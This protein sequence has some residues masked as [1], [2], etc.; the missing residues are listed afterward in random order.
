MA[1][2][3]GLDGVGS[4]LSRLKDFLCTFLHSVETGCEAHPASYPMGT[5]GSFLRD[6]AAGADHADLSNADVKN[7]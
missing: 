1:T 5:T 4:I 2:V 3:Y 7:G 6:R